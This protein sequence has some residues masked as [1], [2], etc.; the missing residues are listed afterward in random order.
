MMGGAVGWAANY[1]SNYRWATPGPQQPL[2]GWGTKGVPTAPSEPSRAVEKFAH[3]PRCEF[4]WCLRCPNGRLL[5]RSGSACA[6]SVDNPLFEFDCG[7]IQLQKTNGHKL[8]AQAMMAIYGFSW[9]LIISISF[10]MDLTKFEDRQIMI[11]EIKAIVLKEEETAKAYEEYILE[12]YDIP[13]LLELEGASYLG[14]SFLIKS[15]W[16]VV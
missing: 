4:P 13:T 3:G 14:S 5:T 10:S 12:N 2:E 1:N 15:S 11:D 9:F 7:K 8:P 16:P 6:V